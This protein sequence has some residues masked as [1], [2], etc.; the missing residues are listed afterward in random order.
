MAPRCLRLVLLSSKVKQVRSVRIS[1]M[2]F[3]E[4]RLGVNLV[5]YKS[6]LDFSPKFNF[7]FGEG[8]DVKTKSLAFG[9]K[10]FIL[11]KICDKSYR[12]Y[13]EFYTLL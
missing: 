11:L 2:G 7:S 13:L 5:S 1:G 3:A 10:N 6:P 4:L 12:C 9:T 8:I